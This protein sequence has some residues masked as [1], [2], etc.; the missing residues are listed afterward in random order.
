[1][2]YTDGVVS[3]SLPKYVATAEIDV[4]SY[5]GGKSGTES[6]FRRHCPSWFVEPLFLCNDG[7]NLEYP[8]LGKCS[9]VYILVHMLQTLSHLISLGI[10]PVSLIISILLPCLFNNILLPLRLSLHCGPWRSGLSL[11]DQSI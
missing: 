6:G 10:R 11:F 1:M 3:R 8:S 7:D 4:L 9:V 5:Y 2:L